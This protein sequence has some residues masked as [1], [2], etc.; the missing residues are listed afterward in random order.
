[1]SIP[2]MRCEIFR[3]SQRNTSF[4]QNKTDILQNAM[5]IPNYSKMPQAFDLQSADNQA[6]CMQNCNFPIASSTHCTPQLERNSEVIY[7][8]CMFSL[9]TREKFIQI[10]ILFTQV[11]TVFVSF[12]LNTTT[13]PLRST[14]GDLLLYTKASKIH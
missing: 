3:P 9:R 5:L 4:W 1:M 7:Q 10:L 8:V 12:H 6:L 14:Y 11:E 2:I 13:A